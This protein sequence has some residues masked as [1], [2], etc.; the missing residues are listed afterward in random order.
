MRRGARPVG[1]PARRAGPRLA[2]GRAPRLGVDLDGRCRRRRPGA[3]A[4]LVVDGP[5]RLAPGPGRRAVPCR[6]QLPAA[7]R[8]PARPFARGL[9]AC[10]VD[11]DR[12]RRRFPDSDR[13]RRGFRPHVAHGGGFAAAAA[14]R[15]DGR[16]RGECRPLAGRGLDPA[17]LQHRPCRLRAARRR[18]RRRARGHQGRVLQPQRH[19]ARDRDHH[20][21]LLRPRAELRARRPRDGREL[22]GGFPPRLRRGHLDPRR[23]AG[24][25]RP[26]PR[27]ELDRHQ[28]GRAGL[29]FRRMLAERIEAEAGA[30]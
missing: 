11:R 27:R 9:C 20:A 7:Q 1:D 16:V 30:G 6:G 23:P 3:G 15:P 17:G 18:R 21:L 19:D 2:A 14:L 24:E 13:A 12:Q 29:A 10:G 5:S 26:P 22:P 4:R 28:R 8:Q 25:Y